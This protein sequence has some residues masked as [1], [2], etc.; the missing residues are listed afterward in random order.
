MYVKSKVSFTKCKIAILSDKIL[1]DVS[2]S[3]IFLSGIHQ[4]IL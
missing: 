1:C 2:G 3:V 4:G